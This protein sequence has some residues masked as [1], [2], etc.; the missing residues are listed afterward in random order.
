M[1]NH[2]TPWDGSE[3][4]PRSFDQ[5]MNESVRAHRWEVAGVDFFKRGV[6]CCVYCGQVRPEESWRKRGYTLR[7]EWKQDSAFGDEPYVEME[8]VAPPDHVPD[9]VGP[10][11]ED[12]GAER[13]S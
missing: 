8:F 10:E 13:T 9:S 2:F 3:F 1:S 5:R 4:C 11:F 7:L 12:Q 6:E